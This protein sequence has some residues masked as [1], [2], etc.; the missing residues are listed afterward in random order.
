[1]EIKELKEAL[2]ELKTSLEEGLDKKAQKAFE[3]EI[4]SLEKE[5]KALEKTGEDITELKG[6]ISD[7]KEA[8]KKNQDLLDQ[9]AVAFKNGIPSMDNG[10]PKSFGQH[11]ADGVKAMKEAIT[12]FADGKTKGAKAPLSEKAVQDMTTATNLT[13]AI[14]ITYRNEIIPLPFEMVHFRSLVSVTPSATDS[15]HFY[16]HVLGEGTI[17][18]Q[19]GENNT[20]AQIDEDLT[21]VTV[22]L[23]YLA[24]WLRISKKMLRNFSA[25]QSYLSRWLPERYYQ[26]EDALAY[27][28]L[29][30]GI[31]TSTVTTGNVLNR[32]IL[33]MAQQKQAK[34]GVNGI[35]VNGNTWGALLTVMA[36]GSGQYTLPNVVTISPAG[37]VMILGVPVYTATWVPDNRAIVGDWRMFEIIQSEGLSL[38]FYEQ[39]QDNV[40][41]NKI[42][43][44]IEASIG[45]ALLQPAAFKLVDTTPEA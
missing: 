25:L 22:N 45:F 38:N 20:K 5:L 17:G 9:F 21:E 6:Q 16:R 28:A 26:R 24:G 40:I 36:E 18:F 13:G 31:G 30:A 27:A 19:G 12:N 32:I 44:L 3:K 39:D 2:D 14:P 10:K 33:T 42:T 29:A 23:D 4:K 41:K 7:M 8:N 34:Y 11:I 37:Q 15:Y 43:A 1:M 35:V